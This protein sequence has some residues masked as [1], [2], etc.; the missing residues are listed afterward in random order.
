MAKLAHSQRA[1]EIRKLIR[2]TLLSIE[3]KANNEY[4][5]GILTYLFYIKVNIMLW[6][7][8]AQVTLL[9]IHLLLLHICYKVPSTY[10]S[11][12]PLT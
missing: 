2:H 7:D 6:F 3:N 12:I 4:N 1:E 8:E 5:D 10:N 9:C 11:L